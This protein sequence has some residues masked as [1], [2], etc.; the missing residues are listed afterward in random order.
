[1]NKYLSAIEMLRSI[2]FPPVIKIIL[3]FFLSLSIM[4]ILCYWIADSAITS[5]A[6]WKVATLWLLVFLWFLLNVFNISSYVKQIK[7]Y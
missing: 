6:T 4:C 5:P 2:K 7:E 3:K 1:M